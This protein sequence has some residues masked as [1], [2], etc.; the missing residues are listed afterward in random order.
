MLEACEDPSDTRHLVWRSRA[1]C[2][3]EPC[4]SPNY[5]VLNHTWSNKR[6]PT[7]PHELWN[8]CILRCKGHSY[9]SLGFHLLS[10]SFL[11]EKIVWQEK[12]LQL[13]L[14]HLQPDSQERTHVDKNVISSKLKEIFSNS[15]L[16]YW[17]V[18]K[19]S[20]THKIPK[21]RWRSRKSPTYIQNQI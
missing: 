6:D 9:T 4:S 11:Q 21:D 2:A 14:E 12:V 5:Y 18:P 1:V 19:N 20:L 7:L 10:F 16:W 17:V 8:F 13:L 15:K 3:C